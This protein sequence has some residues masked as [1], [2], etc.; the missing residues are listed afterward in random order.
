M[1]AIVELRKDL[2]NWRMSRNEFAKLSGM[3]A[4][5]F[6]AALRA[7]GETT[8]AMDK[9][10][11]EKG[12]KMMVER[13]PGLPDQVPRPLRRLWQDRPRRRVRQHQ[14]ARR[15]RQRPQRPRAQD[16]PRPPR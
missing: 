16:R 7:G 8:V 1:G 9:A 13:L 5:E 15:Q 12:D 2:L 6:D 4:S 3:T 14:R 10:V 11:E